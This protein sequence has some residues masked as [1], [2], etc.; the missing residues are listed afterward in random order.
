MTW[1]LHNATA[2]MRTVIFCSKE[3]HCLNDL[4]FRWKTGLLS[5]PPL[6]VRP[7]EEARPPK[8]PSTPAAAAAATTTTIT[9]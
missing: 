6:R 1:T 4:L 5:R 7:T 2:P 9:P 3:G 8:I